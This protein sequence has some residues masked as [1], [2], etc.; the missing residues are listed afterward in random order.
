MALLDIG[1]PGMTGYE[2]AQRMRAAAGTS[3]RLIAVSGYGQAEDRAR[4]RAAGFDVHLVKP[5]LIDD[6][7]P[8]LTG[9]TKR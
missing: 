8:V 9:G 5:V 4:S 3:L 1:L 2:L 7:R 6:L